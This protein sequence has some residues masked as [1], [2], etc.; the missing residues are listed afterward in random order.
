MSLPASGLGSVCQ[1]LL[2]FSNL[3]CGLLWGFLVRGFQNGESS[4]ILFFWLV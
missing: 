3:C 4:E 2:C 1:A